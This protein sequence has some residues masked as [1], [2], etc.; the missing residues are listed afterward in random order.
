MLKIGITQGD[1]NGVG[2]E[3][4]LKTL[5]HKHITDLC[6]PIIYGSAKA[7]GYY[8][9]LFKLDNVHLSLINSVE[10]ISHNRP[11]LINAVSKDV[12]VDS[13]QANTETGLQAYEALERAMDDLKAGKIDA[14]VTAPINK[15]TIQSEQFKFPGHTEYLQSKSDSGEAL[16]IL[17]SETIRVALVTTHIPIT[18][19]KE[20]LTQERIESKLNL[21]NQSL[22][23]DFGIVRPRI[24]VLGLNAHAGDHGVIGHEE[25]EII[26]PALKTAIE[27]GIVCVGPL[28]ADGFFG[29]GAFKKYDAVLAMYHDQGL[30]PFKAICMNQ[31][32]NITAGLPFVRTSPD[33]GTGY[34]IAGKN[35]ANESSMRE[36]IYAAVDIAEKRKFVDKI[37]EDPLPFPRHEERRPPRVMKPFPPK[38]NNY[39]NK[40]ETQKV[41]K[42]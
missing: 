22:K 28:A 20:Q 33:H 32:V 41:E 2:L 11:Y 38:K 9:K 15:S 39:N 25:E 7:A 1:I 3:V 16:M 37:N 13:G 31:G 12:K 21:L 26:I 6:I 17:A 8:K 30:A 23:R 19:I 14:L 40:P 5:R 35:K 42:E 36:A 34:D 18:E 24:A 29:S 10:D 4:I 27:K